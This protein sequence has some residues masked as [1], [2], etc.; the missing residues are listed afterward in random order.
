[1]LF[2]TPEIIFDKFCCAHVAGHNV[3]DYGDLQFQQLQ[4]DPPSN[5]IKSPRTIGAA[6]KKVGMVKQVMGYSLTVGSQFP[7]KS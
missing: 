4:K 6:T 7:D 2:L 1:M 5:N 3:I